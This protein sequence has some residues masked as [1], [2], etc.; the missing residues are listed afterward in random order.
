MVAILSMGPCRGSDARFFWYR[1]RC[2]CGGSLGR[3]TIDLFL[4]GSMRA[5]KKT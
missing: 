3:G 1:L 4:V 2:L 5:N